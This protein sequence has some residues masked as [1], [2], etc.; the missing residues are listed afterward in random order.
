MLIDH[1]I[2]IRKKVKQQMLRASQ[3]RA[4]GSRGGDVALLTFPLVPRQ[5]TSEEP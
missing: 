1:F 2:L 4:C 5:N 3:F